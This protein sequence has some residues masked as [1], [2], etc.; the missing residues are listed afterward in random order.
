[1][2]P[3]F[4]ITVFGVLAAF[5]AFAAMIIAPTLGKH[6]PK[7]A[8]LMGLAQW[9]LTIA[10]LVCAVVSIFN[11]ADGNVPLAMSLLIVT[12]VLVVGACIGFVLASLPLSR[13][14]DGSPNVE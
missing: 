12:V 14:Q 3:E 8:E 11:L 9:V 4:G 2:E 7:L 1:M 5:L 13:E 6:I 10:S